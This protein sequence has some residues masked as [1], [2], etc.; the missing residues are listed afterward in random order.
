MKLFVWDCVVDSN[1]CHTEKGKYVFCLHCEIK[2]SEMIILEQGGQCICPYCNMYLSEFEKVFVQI[3]QSLIEMF[4][5]VKM[6]ILE[7]GGL[8]G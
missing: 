6:I 7:Q 4:S 1:L 2:P 8:L 5:P 3:S